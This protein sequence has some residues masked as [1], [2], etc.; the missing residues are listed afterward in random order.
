MVVE[1][2]VVLYS[3]PASNVFLFRRIFLGKKHKSDDAGDLL[4]T[5]AMRLYTHARAFI[6]TMMSSI[7]GWGKG[8]L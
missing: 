2:V 6:L 8:G 1:P 5:K 3:M 7:L 4:G